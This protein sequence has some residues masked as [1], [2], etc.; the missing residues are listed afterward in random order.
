MIEMA[1]DALDALRRRDALAALQKQERKD[2]GKT[3]DTATPIQ[4]EEIGFS[5]GIESSRLSNL[6]LGTRLRMDK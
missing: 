4:P 6:N 1:E 2:D 3:Q 5:T